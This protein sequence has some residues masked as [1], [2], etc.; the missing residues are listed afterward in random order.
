MAGD[1][2]LLTL[3]SSF[4]PIFLGFFLLIFSSFDLMLRSSLSLLI[5]ETYSADDRDKSETNYRPRLL[6]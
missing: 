3:G 5:M 2:L 1:L 4:W 6:Q